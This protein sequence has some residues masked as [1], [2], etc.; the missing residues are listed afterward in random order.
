M[1]ITRVLWA[2][3]VVT[4][5]ELHIN[6][7]IVQ[8][9][10]ISQLYVIDRDTMIQNDQKTDL[11]VG[12]LTKTTKT[13]KHEKSRKH[14]EN[15]YFFFDELPLDWGKNLFSDMDKLHPNCGKTVCFS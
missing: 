9:I 1:H 15:H 14:Y 4:Y 2:N 10:N 11:K 3:R 12:D 7:K 13:F 5:Y 6:W 8:E